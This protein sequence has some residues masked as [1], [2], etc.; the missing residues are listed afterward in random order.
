MKSETGKSYSHKPHLGSLPHDRRTNDP[1]KLQERLD[2]IDERMEANDDEIKKLE[3]ER[4]ELVT[5]HQDFQNEINE[6]EEEIVHLSEDYEGVMGD[7]AE[8]WEEFKEQAEMGGFDIE[9]TYENAPDDWEEEDFDEF[10]EEYKEDML[11]PM[12]DL[13]ARI[14]DFFEASPEDLMDPESLGNLKALNNDINSFMESGFL[15]EDTQALYGNLFDDSIDIIEDM[16]EAQNVI[17][18][19]LKFLEENKDTS[20]L[21]SNPKIKEI[22]DRLDQLYMEQDDYV[23]E[24][25]RTEAKKEGG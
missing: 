4:E 23:E 13:D 12:Y 1:E 15:D 22:D 5:Q 10:A 19:D 25:K 11:A 7:A 3:K 8:L 17:D 2:A 20:D 9:P 6:K 24:R 14:D 18:M 16:K 21:N